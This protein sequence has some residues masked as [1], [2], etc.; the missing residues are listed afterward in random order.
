LV[1]ARLRQWLLDA[2]AS[3]DAAIA[4]LDATA[5]SLDAAAASLDTTEE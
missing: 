3:I 5:A 4:S 1:S 2:A